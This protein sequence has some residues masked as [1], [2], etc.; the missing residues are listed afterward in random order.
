MDDELDRP[1]E[2]NAAEEWEA[3]DAPGGID[4][5]GDIVTLPISRGDSSTVRKAIERLYPDADVRRRCLSLLAESVSTAHEVSPTSW[6]LTLRDGDVRLNVGPLETFLLLPDELMLV[7]DEA[8]VTPDQWRR[9]KEELG[10]RWKWDGRPFKVIPSAYGVHLPIERLDDAL[11][12]VHRP[13]LALVQRAARTVRIRTKYYQAHS[14]DVVEYIRHELDQRVP[15]PNYDLNPPNGKPR[16]FWKIFPGRDGVAWDEFRNRGM[17]AMEWGGTRDLREEIPTTRTAL[18]DRIG[19]SGALSPAQLGI[20]ASQL[21][22]FYREVAPGDL[23]CAYANGQI[24]GWGTVIGEY[25]Y[26]E[27]DLGFAHRR[28]VRWQSLAPV[29]TTLLSPELRRKLQGR[30]TL[31]PLT[32]EDFQEIMEAAPPPPSDVKEMLRQSLAGTGLAFTTWQVATFYTALQT[33][34]FVILSGISGTGK[35]KLAQHLAAMLPQPAAQVETVAD[36]LVM[37]MR[38]YMR[39]HRRFSLP[40]RTRQFFDL[41]EPGKP[42]DVEVRAGDVSARCRLGTWQPTPGGTQLLLKDP[43]AKWFVERFSEGD[44]FAV[45]PTVDEEG[46]LRALHIV[47]GDEVPPSAAGDEAIPGR[48]ALFLSVRPDWRDSKSLLGYFNPLTEAY[49]WTPFLHFVLRSVRSFGSQDGLAWFVILDEM[50]LAHVEYYFADL[51]SVLESGRDEAGWT[52]EPLRLV[53]PEDAA[54][55]V[56]PPEIF[57]PPN[58]YV[59][60]TVNVDETTHA[61]SPKVLDRAFS[62]ELSAVDFANYPPAPT[63]GFALSVAESAALLDAFTDGG[64]F[65]RIDK[66]VIARFIEAH[67]EIRHRLQALNERLEPHNLHFGYRVFD[68]IVC[69]LDRAQRNGTFAGLGGADAAF[70]AAI[71]MKVLPKFHGSR[72]KLEAPLRAVLAWCTD[73]GTPTGPSQE[74]ATSRFQRTADRVK[75]M[76]NDLERDGFAAFG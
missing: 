41:P 55:E 46:R 27:D 21:W 23:V 72:G 12:V 17:V 15:D 71:L 48:N 33:K 58:L 1:V 9:I 64:R 62:L 40:S 70:D 56:P 59:V 37:T 51:L 34:G 2:A 50:N 10:F 6:G 19:S 32:E 24:L 45:E 8:S 11:P 73:P 44:R 61:F 52:R 76:L 35:T 26:E 74:T 60:G 7:L 68:E 22:S 3:E 30:L 39:T 42:W 67:P 57:L 4:D 47:P 38:P 75:R 66:E 63:D 29:A 54:G 36:Q 53:Y 69:F 25:D 18:K 13:H 20:A 14:P 5:R 28:A 49:E 43:V 31:I 65:P 16:H